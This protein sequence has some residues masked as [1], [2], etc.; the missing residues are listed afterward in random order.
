MRDG[1]KAVMYARRMMKIYSTPSPGAYEI[2]ACA[3]ARDG[4]YSKAVEK[5]QKAIAAME[6]RR[7][8]KLHSGDEYLRKMDQFSNNKAWP[9]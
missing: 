4:Q 6:K 3:L 9:N 2:M 7:G 8:E 5:M 1:K